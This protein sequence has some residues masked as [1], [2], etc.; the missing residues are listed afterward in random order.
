MAFITP[1][2]ASIIEANFT[3]FQASGWAPN[4]FLPDSRV[5]TLVETQAYV[6][7]ETIQYIDYVALQVTPFTATGEYLEAWG[8][9]RGILRHDAAQATGTVVF[10][11]T[12]GT[13]IP[14]GTVV[15]RSDG[16]TYRTT[17][18]GIVGASIPLISE[19]GGSITNTPVATTVYLYNSIEAVS[20]TATVGVIGISGGADMEEDDDLRTRIMLSFQNPGQ[21][22]SEADYVNGALEVSGVTRAWCS[23][24]GMGHGTVSLY[25]MFDDNSITNGFPAGTYG[26]ATKEDR[27]NTK[28]SGDLLPV[29]NHIYEERPV[30]ALVFVIP[31]EPLH[32]P[33]V[34]SGVSDTTTRANIRASLLQLHRDIG[35]P[36]GMTVQPSDILGAIRNAVGTATFTMSAPLS[37][38]TVERGYLP[39]IT[40]G[41]VTFV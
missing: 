32:I 39:I 31:P 23:P 7:Y 28:A 12:A 38:I 8:Q 33:V 4:G 36:L 1:S 9:W 40:S 2:L 15:R 21:G 19:S 18:E 29:A 27:W 6:G 14:V 5:Q 26:V 37:P 25:P 41:D 17:E 11:G 34:I 35:T 13:A 3:E 30:T 16:Q 22:G 24:R 10:A 20:S